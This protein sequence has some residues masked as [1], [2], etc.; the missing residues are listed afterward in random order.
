MDKLP[1]YYPFFHFRNENWVKAAALHWPHMLRFI[2]HDYL[3]RDPAVVRCLNDE[4]DFSHSTFSPDA[5]SDVGARVEAIFNG[6]YPPVHSPSVR[7][8]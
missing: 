1:L 5:I 3:L 8:I 7:P 6:R 2:P 4:L